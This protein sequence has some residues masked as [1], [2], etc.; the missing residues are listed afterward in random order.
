MNEQG[1]AISDDMGLAISVSNLSFQYKTGDV[2]ALK[3][4]SFQVPPASCVLIRGKSGSGKTTLCYCL[5]GLIPQVVEGAFSGRIVTAGMDVT[6]YRIQTLSRHIGFVLQ[7]PEVQIVGRTVYEDLIFGPRNLLIPKEKIVSELT[8]A[9]LAVGLKGYEDRETYQL[10]GGEKQRLTIAGVLSMKPQVLILD[11]P[12]SELDPAGRKNLFDLLL[13]LKRDAGLTVVIVDQQLAASHPLVD[14]ILWLEDGELKV[15]DSSEECPVS[16]KPLADLPCSEQ[17]VVLSVE[18]LS[19][20]YSPETP[21]LKNINMEIREQDFLALVG[22]NGGGKTTLA[23]HL[24]RLFEPQNGT[25]L[26]KKKSL[27][28]Y[29]RREIARSIGFVFQNPDHQIFETSVEKEIGFGLVQQGID[30]KKIKEKVDEVLR[31]MDLEDYRN[32]HPATLPKGIRQVIGVASIVA[33]SPEILIVDEPTTGLDTTG[34]RLIMSRLQE[35]NDKGT[36]IVMITHDMELVQENCSR[37]IL[38]EQG[39]LKVDMPMMKALKSKEFK[40]FVRL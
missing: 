15:T 38:L 36:A 30:A 13:R 3:H 12:S 26:Y 16:C 22:Y 21:V 2:P 19:F 14:D 23:M 4:I 20:A 27:E 25:V 5:K 24:S 39:R 28:K 34:K 18:N 33:L 40:D 29:S 7:D 8:S 1:N 35:L 31:F 11:E 9:L 37:L 32:H 6:K 10:S 17:P